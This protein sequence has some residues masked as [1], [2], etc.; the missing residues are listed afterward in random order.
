MNRRYCRK[1]GNDY[2]RHYK[3]N[4]SRED[5]LCYLNHHLHLNTR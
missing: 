3:N 4:H 2:A 1:Y 5:M